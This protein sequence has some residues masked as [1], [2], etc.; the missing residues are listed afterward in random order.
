MFS[1]EQASWVVNCAIFA[2]NVHLASVAVELR[3]LPGRWL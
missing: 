1:V 3:V 2:E